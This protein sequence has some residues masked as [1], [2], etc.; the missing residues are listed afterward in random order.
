MRAAVEKKELADSFSVIND[1]NIPVRFANIGA[2][3]LIDQA[4]PAFRDADIDYVMDL[5]HADFLIIH[6]NFLQEMIQPEGDRNGKGVKKRVSEIA[7]SYPVIVKETGNGFSREDALELKD[8][9][10]RAIDVGGA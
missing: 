2:P 7:S 6:F 8:A 1:F 9:G 10:V 5:I 3:Q 4:K